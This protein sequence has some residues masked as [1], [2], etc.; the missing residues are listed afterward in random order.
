MTRLFGAALAVG[1]AALGACARPPSPAEIAARAVT[2][3]PADDRLAS[4]YE[5]SCRACHAETRASAPLAGDRAAW[6]PRLAKG[7][8]ALLQSIVAGYNGMPA[9]GQCFTC[10]PQDYEAL[11]RFMAGEAGQ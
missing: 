1:L 5:H 9:G 10:T 8:P 6:Q 11:V 2:L 4:L 3:R 7:M